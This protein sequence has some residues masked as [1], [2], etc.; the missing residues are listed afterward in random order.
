MLLLALGFPSGQ[1]VA[2]LALTE[3]S[4]LPQR[5]AIRLTLTS[6]RS[7]LA[8]FSTAIRGD[9]IYPSRLDMTGIYLLVGTSRC[10][11]AQLPRQRWTWA[12]PRN[13]L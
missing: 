13:I 6:Y 12:D 10:S 2:A 8:Q 11:P 9:R 3:A 7:D 1:A 4:P 5:I